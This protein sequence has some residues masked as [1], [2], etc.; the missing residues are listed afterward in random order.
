[1]GWAGALQ[2]WV[3]PRLKIIG[4]LVSSMVFCFFLFFFW[5]YWFLQWFL[6]VFVR[7]IGFLKVFLVFEWI[8][9][10]AG[11]LGG[12]ASGVKTRNHWF[13]KPGNHLLDVSFASRR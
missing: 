6:G 4:F 11:W 8:G 3:V 5:F 9:W 10:Q 13:D 12:S 1:M 2:S 7:F